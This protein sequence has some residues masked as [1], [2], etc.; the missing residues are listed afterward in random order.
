MS[1]TAFDN[2]LGDRAARDCTCE[3]QAHCYRRSPKLGVAGSSPVVRLGRPRAMMTPCSHVRQL[4]P[5]A[6]PSW[7]PSASRRS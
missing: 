3:A 4:T 1:P 2:G 5:L 6:V 7:C